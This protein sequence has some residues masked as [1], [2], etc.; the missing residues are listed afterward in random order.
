[1]WY[2]TTD[3]KPVALANDAYTQNW[4][5]DVKLG[6]VDLSNGSRNWLSTNSETSLFVGQ[7]LKSVILPGDISGI[8]EYVFKDNKYL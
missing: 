3:G 2:S 8:N 6:D 4:D 1:L 7:T 5:Y